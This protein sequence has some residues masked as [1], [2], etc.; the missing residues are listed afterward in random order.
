LHGTVCLFSQRLAHIGYVKT[1]AECKGHLKKKGCAGAEICTIPKKG[2]FCG[3]GPQE[4]G[5]TSNGKKTYGLEAC[6]SFDSSCRIKSG[7]ESCSV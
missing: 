1:N 4:F 3:F 5:E 6:R 2:D 7:H